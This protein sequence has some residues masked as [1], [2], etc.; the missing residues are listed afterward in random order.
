MHGKMAKGK[1]FVFAI[2][3]CQEM[4]I[5][6]S[7]IKVVQMLDPLCRLIVATPKRPASANNTPRRVHLSLSILIGL[8]LNP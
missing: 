2:M 4:S 1:F 5:L 7:V 3:E 6:N 8:L